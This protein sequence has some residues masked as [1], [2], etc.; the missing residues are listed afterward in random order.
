MFFNQ[1]TIRT[2]GTE[3]TRYQTSD[4]WSPGGLGIELKV[5]DIPCA[6]PFLAL[7]W[8]PELELNT[9]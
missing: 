7:T 8:A 6:P 4:V 5:S 9:Q 3:E 1:A 2:G